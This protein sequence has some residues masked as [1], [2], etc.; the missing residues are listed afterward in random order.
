MSREE[1]IAAIV[2]VLVGVATRLLDRY[3]PHDSDTTGR[4]VK[5]RSKTPTVEQ[6]SSGDS[7]VG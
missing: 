3:L 6:S 4:H 2:A 7:D 1:L 5:P